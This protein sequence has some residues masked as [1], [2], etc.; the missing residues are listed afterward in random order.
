MS[1]PDFDKLTSLNDEL[2]QLLNEK[3]LTTTEFDRIRAEAREAVGRHTEFLE[4]ILMY[5]AMVDLADS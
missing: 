5:G 2:E 4:S 3:Q 1:A